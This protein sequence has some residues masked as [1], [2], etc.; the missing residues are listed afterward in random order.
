MLTILLSLYLRLHFFPSCLARANS[1]SAIFLIVFR[2]VRS[3]RSRV[4][5]ICTCEDQRPRL[6]LYTPRNRTHKQANRC[7]NRSAY[8][9]AN[10]GGDRLLSPTQDTKDR[11]RERG[12]QEERVLAKDK[13]A[14]GRP[15]VLFFRQTPLSL[16]LSVKTTYDTIERQRCKTPKGLT[17]QQSTAATAHGRG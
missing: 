4:R 11:G 2:G 14:R 12:G 7:S 8:V 16:S 15:S 1:K 17:R 9:S 13:I 5:V 10:H 6:T 3:D